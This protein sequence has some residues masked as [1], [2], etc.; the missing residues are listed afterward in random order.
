MDLDV[1]DEADLNFSFLFLLFFFPFFYRI[2][3]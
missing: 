3:G 1:L 2:F